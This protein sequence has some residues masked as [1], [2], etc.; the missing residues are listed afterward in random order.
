[1]VL[2]YLKLVIVHEKGIKMVK[3]ISK[4]SESCFLSKIKTDNKM[5]KMLRKSLQGSNI[6]I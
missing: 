4:E 6:V 5:K 2:T 3:S 1:M